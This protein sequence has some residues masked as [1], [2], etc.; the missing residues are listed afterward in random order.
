MRI[1]CVDDEDIGLKALKK[2]VKTADPESE[3]IAFNYPEDALE[4]V[5]ENKVD[6]AFLDI[7]MVSMSGIELAKKIKI[8]SAATSIVFATGFD[9]YM[10]DAFQ[11]HASGYILKPVTAA[12]VREELKNIQSLRDNISEELTTKNEKRVVF[13]CFGNFE[14][15]CDGVPLHFK[16]DK[17][18][19]MLAYIVSRRGALCT[20]GEIIVNLWEDDNSHDSYLRGVRKN[21]VDILKEKGLEKIIYQQ[22][23]KIGINVNEVEC[24]Y[25]N[26][27]NGDVSAINKYHG[28]FMYQYHWGEM[29][30]AEI[31]H[32]K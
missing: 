18:K 20:N 5:K 27:L 4:Y 19:E 2:A 3:I 22:R 16:Y 10:K 28:E 29:I 14:V 15:F 9:D 23:G 24:D 26:F 30:N 6:I 12:K 8:L 25:Y 13:H 32:H 17:T 1:L 21:L 11:L 7:F 31:I